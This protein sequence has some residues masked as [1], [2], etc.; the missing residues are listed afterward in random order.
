MFVNDVNAI[1]HA[2]PYTPDCI[3]N[4]DQSRFEYE[5]TASRTLSEQGEKHTTALI[6]SMTSVTHS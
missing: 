4:T 6:Q 1:I 3:F 2:K 5:M